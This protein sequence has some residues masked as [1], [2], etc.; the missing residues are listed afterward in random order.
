MSSEIQQRSLLARRLMVAIA[1][2]ILLLVVVGVVLGRQILQ[3]SED[4]RW[5]D[6]TYEVLGTANDTLRQIA[7]QETGLR[8]YLL[9]GDR[10]FLDPFERA[11]PLN[12]FSRLHDLTADNPAQ[13]ARF[14]ETRHRYEAWL[15]TTTAAV[16]GKEVEAAKSM[17]ALLDLVGHHPDRRHAAF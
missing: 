7:D 11:R 17:V 10:V 8:G 5:V 14:E 9:A 16:Q 13:Q 2:P 12:G 6:H 4:A 15:A 1:T 3:M